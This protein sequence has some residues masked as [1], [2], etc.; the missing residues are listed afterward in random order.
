MK[1]FD[2]IVLFVPAPQWNCQMPQAQGATQGLEA[3]EP[4]HQPGGRLK[5]RRF[6]PRQGLRHPSEKLH[7]RSGDPLVQS[8]GH[9]DGFKRLQHL[10]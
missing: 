8:S 4:P 10:C 7:P 6:R 3:T 1:I 2:C 5:A 9:F